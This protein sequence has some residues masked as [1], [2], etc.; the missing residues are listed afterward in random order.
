MLGHLDIQIGK[1]L[2]LTSNSLI[3]L[4]PVQIKELNIKGKCKGPE[5]NIGEFLHNFNVGK[6]NLYKI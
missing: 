3:K 5:D 4:T 6:A 2:N 1:K